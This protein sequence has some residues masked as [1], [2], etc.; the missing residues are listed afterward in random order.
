MKPTPP[1]W[2]LQERSLD[3][4]IGSPHLDESGKVASGF[5]NL[6]ISETVAKCLWGK[7]VT[8]AKATISVINEA[9]EVKT[10]NSSVKVANGYLNFQVSGFTYS[11]NKISIAFGKVS[12]PAN[13]SPPK[14]KS[15]SCK[16]GKVTKVISAKSPKCPKGYKRVA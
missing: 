16:K 1:V 3:F 15:I 12:A 7:D 14:L 8:A 2:N 13:S 5:Y 4:K 9:G 10:F 6:A 11:V